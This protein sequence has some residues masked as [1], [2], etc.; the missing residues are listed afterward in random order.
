[1]DT[2]IALVFLFSTDIAL[3]PSPPGISMSTMDTSAGWLR[4]MEQAG[5][6]AGP[7][8]D[9]PA[10]F[11]SPQARALGMRVPLEHEKLGRVDQV[12]LPFELAATPASI[13]TPPPLLG[14]HTDE[15]LAE[16]GYAPAE[17]EALRAAAVV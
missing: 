3:I 9:L 7:I 17:I 13:R 16:A 10:A 8:L 6:P 11:S 1:M 4:R 5:I 14:E 15:V 2:T 12:G